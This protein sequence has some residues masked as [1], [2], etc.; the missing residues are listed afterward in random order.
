MSVIDTTRSISPG[1]IPAGSR[2]QGVAI[3]PN[4][5]YAYMPFALLG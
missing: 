3:T 5:L 1:S 4:G 2:P